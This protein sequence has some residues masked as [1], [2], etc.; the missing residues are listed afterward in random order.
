MIPIQ[1]H[2]IFGLQPDFGVKPFSFFHYMAV[3]SALSVHPG[4]KAFLYYE[5]EPQGVY[6][7]VAKRYV[8][9]V[10]IK[11]PTEIFGRPLKDVAHQTDLLRLQILHDQGGIYLDLDTITTRGFSTLLQHSCVMA[12]QGYGGTDRGLCN[13]VI[14]SESRHPFIAAWLEEFRH[15]RSGGRD[16]YWD[17]FA[18]VVPQRLMDT[19]KHRVTVLEPEAFFIPSYNALGIATC[20]STSGNF[21]TA[22]ATICGN[23]CRGTWRRASTSGTCRFCRTPFAG[24]PGVTLARMRLCSSA[25]GKPRC[26]N[27]PA[28]ECA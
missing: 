11:A 2:F 23:P 14:L 21:P 17:E 8:K 12:R 13:A 5:H 10:P 22:I 7:E 1:F 24:S 3:K 15:F 27:P 19:G 26:A 25:C 18:A 9:T 28:T 4:A 16:E 20:S 6:W